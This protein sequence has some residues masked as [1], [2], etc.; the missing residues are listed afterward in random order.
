MVCFTSFVWIQNRL[1]SRSIG[2]GMFYVIHIDTFE[3]DWL[4]I[5]KYI[6][7]GILF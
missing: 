5:D 4:N 3:I 7:D 2:I 6:V 1:C